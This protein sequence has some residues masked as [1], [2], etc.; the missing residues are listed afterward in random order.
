MA[1]APGD[2]GL[3]PGDTFWVSAWVPTSAAKF[4]PKPKDIIE[5]MNDRAYDHGHEDPEIEAG[6][7]GEAELAKLLTDWCA[8]HVVSSSLYE[9]DGDPERCQAPAEDQPTELPSEGRGGFD[10]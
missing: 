10:G 2:L 1:E 6:A 7:D 5:M 9:P 4:L 3:M 8:K